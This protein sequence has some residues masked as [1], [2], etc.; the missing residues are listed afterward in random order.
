MLARLLILAAL[1][2]G[3][4][5]LLR[6]LSRVPPEQVARIIR[7]TLLWGG[8]GLLVL[9]TATGRLN[10]LLALIAAA[11]P[12]ALRGLAL[13]QLLPIVQRLFRALGLMG[14]PGQAGASDQSSSV[15]TRFLDMRLDHATG[16]LDGT[17]LVGT[18]RGRRLSQLTLDQ[19]G[20]LLAECRAADAQSAAVLE[21]YLDRIHGEG[22]QDQTRGHADRSSD[23]DFGRL[24]PKEAR[25]ILGVAATATVDE[26]RAA[27][28][29]LMQKY[30]P[31]RGGSDYL[32]AKI[33]AAKQ[34][35]LQ[36]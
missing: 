16:H 7:R 18:L 2:A 23:A 6:W 27:H 24:T 28:R 1:I 9:A 22:W 31:D 21:S 13:L 33:N 19:L 15:R 29:R 5:W 25:A 10:P 20:E 30:H 14:Q 32:A 35:L 17:V 11:V 12:V 26:I 8:I 3:A 4:L 34:R 36:E